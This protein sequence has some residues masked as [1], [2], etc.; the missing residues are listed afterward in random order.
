MWLNRKYANSNWNPALGQEFTIKRVTYRVV[1][2]GREKWTIID[3]S[4]NKQYQL[5][6]TELYEKLKKHGICH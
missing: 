1:M 2:V 3:L 6:D 4:N 5:T